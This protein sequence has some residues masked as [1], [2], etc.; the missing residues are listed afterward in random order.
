MLAVLNRYKVL[1]II[2]LLALLA[3]L[4]LLYI[5]LHS[6]SKTPSKGVFVMG[7]GISTHC[8]ERSCEIC[9]RL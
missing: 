7:P 3:A 8:P 5:S 9:N 1:L 2:F 6:G 4:I